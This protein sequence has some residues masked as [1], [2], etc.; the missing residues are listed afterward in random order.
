MVERVQVCEEDNALLQK[1]ATTRSHNVRTKV[2]K[3]LYRRVGFLL[4]MVAHYRKNNCPTVAAIL[5]QLF[6][7]AQVTILPDLAGLARVVRMVR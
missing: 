1:L 2:R 5:H 3:K 7:T 6:P 4:M